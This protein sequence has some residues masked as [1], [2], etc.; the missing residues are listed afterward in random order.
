MDAKNRFS[1][2]AAF[3]SESP[4]D[5]AAHS[6][7]GC[8]GRAKI[9]F[10]PRSTAE[11]KALVQKLEADGLEWYVIGN[12]TN[13][14]PADE[15]TE[16]V[17]ISTKALSGIAITDG[18]FAY[19]GATSGAL[20][21]ACKRAGKSGAEFLSGVPC[22][23]GGAVY[24]NAGAGGRYIA[25]LI[26]SVLVLS[27]GET[28]L[29]PVR[30]CGYAYKK[31]VFM[32]NRDVILGVNLALETASSE[33]IERL[34]NAYKERRKHLPKGRSMG[35]VFKNPEGMFAGDLIERSG[36]KGLRIGGAK[37]SEEHANFI[38]ND[39]NATARDIRALISFIRNA[40]KAQYDVV[41]EEEIRYLT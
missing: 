2:Y 11:M 12:L 22:T 13:V 34:E 7:V 8:G 10:Y 21:T 5:L 35:C 39:G 20:L 15:G 37:I 24:M 40:V 30:D 31:S 1:E 23:V 14:L 28:R 9:V 17:L 26:E 41:L 4:F 38:I 18:A 27:E 19:A 36:L 33:E 25:E 16:K 6:S 3:R 32:E 29:L